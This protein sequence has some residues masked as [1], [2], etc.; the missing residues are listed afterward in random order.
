MDTVTVENNLFVPNTNS[1][2]I[3]TCG[4]NEDDYSAT[5]WESAGY[6]DVVYTNESTTGLRTGYITNG[7]YVIEGAVTIADGGIGGNHPYLSGVTIPSYVGPTDPN[8]NEWVAGVTTDL[9][10]TTWLM[11]TADR[12][13]DDDPDWIEGGSSPAAPQY[14]T[15]VKDANGCSMVKL[16]NGIII[17]KAE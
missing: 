8:D 9:T 16:V 14:T 13:E 3:I 2:T 17:T 12:D 5:T 7:A 11:G 15:I 6:S 4:D 10:N 1:E